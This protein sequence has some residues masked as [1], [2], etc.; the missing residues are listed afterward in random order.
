LCDL[1]VFD[2]DFVV[3]GVYKSRNINHS[4]FRGDQE[5]LPT[6]TDSQTQPKR[7]GANK[8]KTKTIRAVT[9]IIRDVN[10]KRILDVLTWKFI[11][12]RDSQTLST[13][14]FFIEH[15]IEQMGWECGTI[16]WCGKFEQDSIA[17]QFGQ[18]DIDSFKSWFDRQPQ[19]S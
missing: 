6:R 19:V 4:W 16:V 10:G 17:M 12:L 9:P 13:L 2:P 1:D 14:Q 7:A 3:F 8:M 11:G 5:R 18:A 15:R